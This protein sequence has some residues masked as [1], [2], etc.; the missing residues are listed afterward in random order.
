MMSNE[1]GKP[2][3][4]TGAQGAD[5]LADG[6]SQ[7]GSHGYSALAG[8]AK[9]E[10]A[11]T[12]TASNDAFS[13]S[14]ASG[15]ATG[16]R[17]DSV[18]STAE[19]WAG[20]HTVSDTDRRDEAPAGA[21]YSGRHSGTDA[22]AGGPGSPGGSPASSGDPA[23]GADAGQPGELGTGQDGDADGE[24]DADGA[25][26]RKRRFSTWRELPILIIVALVIALVIKTFVVQPFF[27]PSS[28]MENTLLIGDKVLVN[29]L[30]Y[31]FRSIQP[32]DIVVF[33]GD[34]SWD[35]NPPPSPPASNVVAHAY[36]VTLRPLF[37]SIAG[38]FGTPV[39]QTDYV[40]R[41]IGVPGDRVTCCNAQGLVTVNGVPLHETSYIFPGASPSQIHFN[42]VVPKGRLWVM[43]DNR[44]VSDDSRMRQG[45]PGGGTIPENKVIGRAFMI[46]WPPSR[47][48]ILPI[49]S[50]FSQPGISRS[51]SAA[52]TTAEREAAAEMLG[53]RVQPGTSY[54][55]LAAGLVG[56][57][58][59]TW[60][61]L[62]V[63][64]RLGRRLRRRRLHRHS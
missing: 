1:H 11:G 42:I 13:A 19:F 46:I 24:K 22:A 50:T 14:S 21:G 35:P 36:D 63:R 37:H 47:W 12:G 17:R 26:K 43:G 45:D 3:R 25:D 60:L 2:D 28:S 44:Q 4:A 52:S 23:G 34:G 5:E 16:G 64:R 62:R 54:L 53:A 57:V 29:K 38:L 30:I 20:A 32:G 51:S 18:D 8:G 41:V 40:K 27:I 58:P 55:P 31:H 33:N 39:G 59:L 6:V 15:G 10:S 61:Q 9:P 48:R 49:P 7:N 56:A